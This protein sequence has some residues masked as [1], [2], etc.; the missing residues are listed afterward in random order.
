M[1]NQSFSDESLAHAPTTYANFSSA[2]VGKP[3]ALVNAGW[4]LELAGEANLNWSTTDP[5]ICPKPPR[6]LLDPA[7]NQIPP[8][9]KSSFTFPIKI[10]DSTRTFDGLVGYFL[11]SKSPLSATTSD[12]DLSALYT[13]FTDHLPHPIPPATT[14]DPRVAISISNFPLHTPYWA[15]CGHKGDAHLFNHDARLQVHGL[16]IDPFL[17][18][19]AYTAILP[20]SSLKLPQWSVEN[21]LKKMT[22][23]WRAGPLLVAPDVPASFDPALALTPDYASTLITAFPTTPAAPPG[24]PIPVP[25]TGTTPIPTVPIPLAPPA[26]SASGAGAAYRWLQPYWAPADPKKPGVDMGSRFNAF[27]VA[28][29]AA[30]GADAVDAR[31]VDGPY[32]VVEGYVQIAKRPEEKNTAAKAAAVEAGKA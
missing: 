2:I 29:D 27:P 15:S 26:G 13:F 17:P 14:S 11:P 30:A 20:N 31:L 19:H 9:D 24:P 12:L 28:A 23:F 1:I 8:N 25:L 4:S 5:P 21:A 7:G 3:L 22:A 6:T 32:T 10:G 16:L 18:V